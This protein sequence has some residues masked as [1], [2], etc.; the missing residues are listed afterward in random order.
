MLLVLLP[1][2]EAGDSA[3]AAEEGVR[4]ECGCTGGMPVNDKR[5]DLVATPLALALALAPLGTFIPSGAAYGEFPL[6]SFWNAALSWCPASK[7]SSLAPSVTEAS[8]SSW[9]SP[10]IGDG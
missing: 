9:C 6:R 2:A 3:A 8:S 10:T 5:G 1:G 7:T 4:P